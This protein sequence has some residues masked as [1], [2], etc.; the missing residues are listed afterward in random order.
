MSNRRWVTAHGKRI[1][2]E[3]LD[4]RSTSRRRKRPKDPTEHFFGCPIWWLKLVRPLIHSKDQLIVAVYL[5]RRYVVCGCNKDFDVPNTE[6]ATFGVGRQTKYD[7]IAILEAAAIIAVKR[8]GK[9]T[10][11]ITILVKRR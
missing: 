10:P 11:T 1:E 5:Y 6:L 3:D 2:I 9:R 4:L 8:H 7:T